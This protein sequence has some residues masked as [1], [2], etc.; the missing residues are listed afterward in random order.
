MRHLIFISR[1]G[2]RLKIGACVERVTL[3]SENPLNPR[4]DYQL[5]AIHF[6]FSEH[7]R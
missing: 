3:L 5:M 2:R 6:E 7:S 4:H 1:G